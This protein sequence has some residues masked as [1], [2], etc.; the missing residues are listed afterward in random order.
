MRRAAME[1]VW[2]HWILCCRHGQRGWNNG[3]GSTGGLGQIKRL[4]A[5]A[6]RSV[7]ITV[8]RLALIT[9]FLSL[10][11]W[12]GEVAVL[13]SGFRIR[14]ERHERAGETIRLYTTRDG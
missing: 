8:K 12:A 13:E 6:S 3:C 9:G 14:I 1:S 4:H 2:R 7:L 5:L 11:A 10:R